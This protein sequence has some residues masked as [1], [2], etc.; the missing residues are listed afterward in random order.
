MKLSKTTEAEPLTRSGF[1]QW[2]RHYMGNVNS[3]MRAPGWVRNGCPSTSTTHSRAPAEHQLNINVASIACDVT[4]LLLLDACLNPAGPS[5]TSAC[6]PKGYS[7]EHKARRRKA[8]QDWEKNYGKPYAFQGKLPPA[9]NV[10][11]GSDKEAVEVAEEASKCW[12]CVL[13]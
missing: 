6:R 9:W 12:C 2:A 7:E 5:A 4:C 10:G 1:E 3:Q 8:S 13:W 11:D